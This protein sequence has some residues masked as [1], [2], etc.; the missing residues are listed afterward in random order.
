MKLSKQDAEKHLRVMALV[1]SDRV[2][3]QDERFQILE[4]FH[5]GAQH[6]NGL[7]GA[8][9]TPIDLAYSVHAE[10]ISGVRSMVDLCAGIGRLS[11]WAHEEGVQLTCVELNP[12]YVAAGRRALPNAQWWQASMFDD[13]VLSLRSEM[14]VSNPPFGRLPA[15]ERPDWIVSQQLHLAAVEVSAMI[16][17]DG[18]FILP[19]ND[20][21]PQ[22]SVRTTS[23][24]RSLRR[25]SVDG[26]VYR[27]EWRNAS[28][29]VDVLCF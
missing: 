17:S 7:A 12:D 8:F 13:N 26:N 16:A 21:V 1:H 18:C 9:F 2:L 22:E 6:L 3:N 24:L 14:V 23:G 20:H 28:P 25:T 4:D 10:Q 19:R 5:E 29:T 11:W 15:K 27:N